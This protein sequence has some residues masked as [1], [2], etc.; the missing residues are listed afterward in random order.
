MFYGITLH[1]CG[2]CPHTLCRT[3]A[4]PPLPGQEKERIEDQKISQKLPAGH[5]ITTTLGDTRR[6]PPD[7]NS[8]KGG[9]SDPKSQQVMRFQA[10][11]AMKE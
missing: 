9:P 10:L 4:R 1:R 11:P 6:T 5:V 2:Q 3:N 8:K 7:T